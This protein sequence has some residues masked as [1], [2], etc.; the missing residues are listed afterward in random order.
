M[1]KSTLMVLLFSLSVMLSG[2]GSMIAD[3]VPVQADKPI[4]VFRSL[5]PDAGKL[6]TYFRDNNTWSPTEA[7]TA[8]TAYDDL[9]RA[10]A[11]LEKHVISGEVEYHR[12]LYFN[13]DVTS[14][15]LRLRPLLDEQVD[16]ELPGANQYAESLYR[17]VRAAVDAMLTDNNIRLA[18]AKDEMDG[19]ARS[20]LLADA[21]QLY[22]VISPLLS[23]VPGVVL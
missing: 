22:S 1:T 21:K 2:C 6:Y 3:S 19:N 16:A 9:V 13:E 5:S 7:V 20:E 14:S 10:F 4:S 18:A 15:W 23:K 12:L 11:K 17:Y 8:K